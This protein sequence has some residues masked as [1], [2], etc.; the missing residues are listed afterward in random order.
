VT[1]APVPGGRPRPT[2]VAASR[3]SVAW[4]PQRAGEGPRTAPEPTGST[5]PDGGPDTA[6]LTG[7]NPAGL[8]HQRG[9]ARATAAVLEVPEA[10]VVPAEDDA[11]PVRAALVRLQ[12]LDPDDPE[13]LR[14]RER[15]VESHLPLVRA[16][17]Q[18]YRDLGEP[19][20]D[21]VQVG[22]IGLIHAV[23]RF[24][25]ERGTG[26]ASYATP[27]ILGEIRRH[28]RDR[29]WAVR[30]PR[31]LQELQARTG[32]ARAEL[33][34][35]LGR[36]PTV[37]EL[38]RAL[39]LEE[40]TVLE[41]LDAQRAYAA[42]PLERPDGQAEVDGALVTVDTGLDEVV[43]RES[44]RPVLRGL[45]AR[46][47]R[48]LALRYFRGLSQAQ[49]AE[50]LGI[51]QM[52]V[53]RLLARTLGRLQQCLA[54]AGDAAADDPRTAAHVGT[55]AAGSAPGGG[56]GRAAGAGTGRS[57]DRRGGSDRRSTDRR[58]EPDRRTGERRTADRRAAD[59]RDP[60]QRPSEQQPSEQQ[61]SG[62]QPSGQPSEHPSAPAGPR[63]GGP[64]RTVG[65]DSGRT[66]GG[67]PRRDVRR[68]C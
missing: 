4:P 5:A 66:S 17:A 8:G 46:E 18:R 35:R 9:S 44:L 68:A 25:P 29:A 33:S 30:V 57:T 54:D 27:N 24:D 67:E 26:L 65:G 23:D 41:A 13:R 21:L 43:D 34:Q 61:P 49:I 51:S 22:T 28:F 58:G 37:T 47:K 52:H 38:A 31:R 6:A 2:R 55:P 42:V 3:S 19:L 50:E 7:P 64:R 15:V 10:E 60:E 20:D 53:S 16:L 32:A 36:S 12:R 40:E 63:T 48:I 39:D 56:A 59:R 1:A 11:A 45:P 62:Q 14:L